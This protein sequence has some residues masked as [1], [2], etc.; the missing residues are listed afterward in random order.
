MLSKIKGGVFLSKMVKPKLWVKFG[1]AN[2]TQV[3]TKECAN[4]DDFIK[5]VKKELAPRFDSVPSDQISISL[6]AKEKEKAWPRNTK[7]N[8]IHELRDNDYNHPLFIFVPY[9]LM[10]TSAIQSSEFNGNYSLHTENLQP[11]KKQR[12]DQ[13]IFY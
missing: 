9:N 11:F 2:A 4:I 12:R 1:G 10:S 8:Q 5:A 6:T 7:L 13:G 3:S